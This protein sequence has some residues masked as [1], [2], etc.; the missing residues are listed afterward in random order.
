[1]DVGAAALFHA[2]EPGH[3]ALGK[4]VDGYLELAVH[5]VVGQLADAV[6][7]DVLVLQAVAYEALGRDGLQQG[8]HFLYHAFLQTGLQSACYL[9]ASEV[10][11]YP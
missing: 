5:L 4:L 6:E 2:T 3:L 1:M 7:G 10:A 9:L 8:L 11:V